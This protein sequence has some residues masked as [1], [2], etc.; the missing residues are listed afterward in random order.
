[1]NNELV[2]VITLKNL[3]CMNNHIHRSIEINYT[4]QDGVVYYIENKPIY[5]KKK[6]VIILNA[7]FPHRV[8]I[9]NKSA[10]LISIEIDMPFFEN[11]NCRQL[12]DDGANHQVIMAEN[13]IEAVIEEVQN[14]YYSAG[15]DSHLCNGILFLIELIRKQTNFSI[16]FNAKVYIANNILSISSLDDVAKHLNISA[17]HMQRVFKKE[18]GISIGK[19]ITNIRMKTAEYLLKNTKIPIGEID[20]KIGMNSRQAF[21]SCFKKFYGISPSEYRKQMQNKTRGRFC[22]L[23]VQCKTRQGQDKGTVLL[24]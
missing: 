19:Y 22:C 2:R 13:L 16:S 7:Q 11:L 8:E 20:E 18:T 12:L 4:E 15:C 24:S 14:S 23:M 5:L 9:N 3:Y 17:V 10:R 1:M 6:H 21:Y